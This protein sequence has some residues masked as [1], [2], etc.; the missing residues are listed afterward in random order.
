MNEVEDHF[1]GNWFRAA[2]TETLRSGA[3]NH[4]SLSDIIALPPFERFVYVLTHIEGCTDEECAS[5]LQAP[6]HV[7]QGALRR[8]RRGLEDGKRMIDSSQPA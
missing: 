4:S 2:A 6:S 5:L 8:A 7:I 1:V 3:L